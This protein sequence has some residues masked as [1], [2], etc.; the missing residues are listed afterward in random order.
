MKALQLG[1]HTG[2]AR[3]VAARERAT[4]LAQRVD[5]VVSVENQLK[6]RSN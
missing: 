1:K 5:G 2:A 3:S 4:Q 6:V